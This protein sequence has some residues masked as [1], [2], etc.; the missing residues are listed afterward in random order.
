MSRKR[1]LFVDD[2]PRVIVGL[3]RMLRKQRGEWDMVFVNSAEEALAQQEESHFDVIVSDMQMPGMN[4]A[5]LLECV[6][7]KHPDTARIVLTGNTDEALANRVLRV[8]HQYLCKP[9]DA[10]TLKAAVAQ[11]CS[12]PEAVANKQLRALFGKCD[13]LPSLPSLYVEITQ[14]AERETASAREIADIISRDMGMSAKLLQ[15]VNSSFFGVG[16]RISSVT[17]TVALLGILRIKALVLAE[18]IFEGFAPSRRIDHFSMEDM[19]RHS[20]AVARLARVISEA[21]NQGGDQPDQA[22]NAGLMHE[23]GM[24]ALACQRTDDFEEVLRQVH[25]EGK[26]IC[27][28]EKDRFNATHADMGAYLLTLWGLPKGLVE[29]VA[30]HH[31]PS[32]TPSRGFCAV[33]AVHVA[34]VLVSNRER[35]ESDETPNLFAPELDTTYLDRIG[36]SHRLDR[37]KEFAA[38]ATESAMEPLG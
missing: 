19:W 27:R 10:E 25:E 11:A 36:L 37:W 34:D 9:T 4:G 5:E 1:I 33:S 20:L 24:L 17:Q 22:F 38:E 2:E 16:R 13:T 3:Q 31:T 6:V 12:A 7:K 21:E 32:K 23:I 35:S 30:L 28:A 8:A 26:P 15:L 18:G 14:A 29:A